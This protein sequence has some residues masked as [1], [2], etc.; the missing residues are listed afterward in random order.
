MINTSSELPKELLD[1][2]QRWLI[3]AVTNLGISQNLESSKQNSKQELS[4]NA[5]EK[6]FSKAE[7]LQIAI[8]ATKC[9][10]NCEAARKYHISE[11]A[12]RKCL[13]DFSQ[14]KEYLEAISGETKSNK[15]P[16]YDRFGRYKEMEVSLIVWIG[17]QREKKLSV[18]MKEICQQALKI[19][20]ELYP[21]ATE[22]FK[23]SNGWFGRFCERSK[24]TRRTPTHVLQQFKENVESE[25]KEFW[26][27][28]LIQR[29]KVEILHELEPFKETLFLNIDEVPLQ[30]AMS[31]KK[32]YHPKGS[33]MVECK[34]SVGSRIHCTV[35]LGILS[36]GFKLPIYAIAKT[37][38]KVE[39]PK[40]LE[41]FLII[42]SNSKGWSS[43]ELFEDYLQRLVLNLVLPPNTQLI[44]VLDQAKIHMTSAV[45]NMLRMN[46]SITHHFIPSGCTFL[47]Q[48]LD[49]CVNK[50]YKDKLREAYSDWFKNIGDKPENKTPAG[51]IKAP[52]WK[53]FFEWVVPTWDSISSEIITKSF[54]ICGLTLNLD[55]SEN[56]LVNPRI[57]DHLYIEKELCKFL[58]DKE[59]PYSEKEKLLNILQENEDKFSYEIEASNNHNQAERTEE[60]E[61]VDEDME[62]AEDSEDEEIMQMEEPKKVLVLSEN[63]KKL[64]SNQAE[65]QMEI[66]SA[67]VIGIF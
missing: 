27:K 2:L 21:E 25:I 34:G 23:A 14:D 60:V 35:V 5:K 40:E 62:N 57:Y 17:E 61:E 52:S 16:R 15:R 64:D 10:N 26:K 30:L 43:G 31:Q 54:K 59:D 24:I 51:Y 42:R 18:S 46:P 29:T 67:S 1:Q 41:N 55:H 3:S 13:K 4:K 9:R 45:M 33:K 44:V 7:R 49:V 39:V 58:F 12:V 53:T 32:T 28:I 47:L 48:P 8:Y 20:K 56:H 66:E 37:K 19:F 63:S 22:E 11:T 6:K 65:I 50:P 38:S 36:N